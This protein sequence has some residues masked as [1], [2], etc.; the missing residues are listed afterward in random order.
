MRARN[1][2]FH[3]HCFRCILCERQLNTGDEFGIDAKDGTIFCR[4]HYLFHL[5]QQQQ[6]QQQQQNH[7]LQQ[8]QNLTTFVKTEA[9]LH[10]SPY[11]LSNSTGLGKATQKSTQKCRYICIW[12][13][14]C[15]IQCIESRPFSK[16]NSNV[17]LIQNLKWFVLMKNNIS[18]VLMQKIYQ[19]LFE[20]ISHFKNWIYKK[21]LLYRIRPFELFT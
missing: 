2:V 3:M 5:Q 16:T 18:N 7:H 19:K 17:N 13:Y 9:G 12:N 21:S 10:N 8:Q 11:E 1:F 4:M 15:Y 20:S 6:Q 14:Q